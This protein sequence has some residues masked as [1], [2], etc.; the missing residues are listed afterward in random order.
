MTR[1][2][3]EVLVP[4]V[5]S[6]MDSN[7]FRNKNKWI[8]SSFTIR[9]WWFF[10]PDRLDKNAHNG[11]I[12]ECCRNNIIAKLLKLESLPSDIKAIFCWNVYQK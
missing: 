12:L 10:M 11:G 3:F 8:I 2:K 6:D 1:K 4:V 9:D 7:D 5:T